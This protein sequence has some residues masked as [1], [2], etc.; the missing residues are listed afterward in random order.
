MHYCEPR[1]AGERTLLAEALAAALDGPLRSYARERVVE[2]GLGRKFAYVVS[3]GGH[4]GLAFSWSEEPI[5]TRLLEDDV[6]L[7][8]LASY[9]WQHPVLTSVALAAANAAMQ[10]LIDED[11]GV[12]CFNC[13]FVDLLDDIRGWKVAVVGYVP[14]ITRGLV[15]KGA[16]VVLFEDNPMHRREAERDL[17]LDALPGSQLLA[18]NSSFDAIVATGASLIDPRVYIASKLLKPKLFAVVGPTSSFHPETARRLGLNVYGGSY[19]PPE[20][21]ARVLKLVKAGYGFRALRKYVQK[22]SVKL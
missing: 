8:E 22:W 15:E 14:G 11:K 12:V 3:E 2:V 9:A 18:F 4:V 10:A 6:T 21:R 16:R 17:G 20:N 13:D 19:I 7:G 1:L 5:P